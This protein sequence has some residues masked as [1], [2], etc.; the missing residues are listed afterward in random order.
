MKKI[1]LLIGVFFSNVATAD[2]TVSYIWIVSDNSVL[3]TGFLEPSNNLQGRT[4]TMS[5]SVHATGTI[6][7]SSSQTLQANVS[8]SAIAYTGGHQHGNPP[9]G[10]F[11][12]VSGNMG[13]INNFPEYRFST[14]YTAPENA[15]SFLIRGEVG[16]KIKT[17]ILTVGILGLVDLYP[18]ST[19]TYR[20]I[21]VPVNDP[22]H[23]NNVYATPEVITAL[24]ETARE[25]HDYWNGLPE[26]ERSQYDSEVGRLQINDCSLVWGGLFDHRNTWRYPH[27]THRKGLDTD[28]RLDRSANDGGIPNVP[29]YVDRFR[30][31]LKAAY[32]AGTVVDIHN[33]N[34]W[35][36]DW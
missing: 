21:G 10:T 25:W 34:H 36:I 30:T 15:G 35:H 18:V 31:I 8:V 7:G 33:S 24:K 22:T 23:P 6:N 3:S 32:D 13:L 17:K 29:K 5:L 27:K 12:P 28:I 14:T 19:N 4:S 16:G 1:I 9:S 26:A 2:I 20:R 11:N